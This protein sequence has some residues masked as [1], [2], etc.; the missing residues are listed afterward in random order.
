MNYH[1]SEREMKFKLNYLQEGL[2][3]EHQDTRKMLENI[4]RENH[5]AIQILFKDEGEIRSISN[6]IE[7]AENVYLSHMSDEDILKW[8]NKPSTRWT[9]LNDDQKEVLMQLTNL[10]AKKVSDYFEDKGDLMIFRKTVM[11]FINHKANDVSPHFDAS[12]FV[13]YLTEE[14]SYEDTVFNHGMSPE[15]DDKTG[16]MTLDKLKI[17]PKKLKL[18]ST[19]NKLVNY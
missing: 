12:K 7:Y 8:R 1:K 19:K 10:Y 11:Y 4:I 13:E 3:L 14:Y 15:I 9:F 18:V 2:E 16:L 5:A 17:H 6:M